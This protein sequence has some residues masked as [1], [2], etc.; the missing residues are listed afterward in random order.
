M[1]TGYLHLFL[2]NVATNLNQF[3]T[4]KQSR[5]DGSQ[6]IGCSDEHHFGQII[7]HIQIV[8]ME[9]MV[10]FRIQHFQHCRTW[11][12]TMV[13]S[14]FVYFIQ[15]NHR[16]RCFCL[17]KTLNDTSRHS[18]YV[19]FTMSANFRFIVYATQRH[20]DILT[21]QRRCDRASQRRFTYS[22]RAIQ[23]NNRRF[24]IVL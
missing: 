18:T 17:D 7:I 3:H 19:C 23:T 9:R 5:R 6:V 13:T 22:R 12:T 1:T 4:V 2:S 10:L 21:F 11:I 16:I 8:V 24:H 20:T 14:Q 15:N